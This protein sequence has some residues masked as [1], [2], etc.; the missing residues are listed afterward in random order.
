MAL[1]IL[2]I[3][4]SVRKDRIGIRPARYLHQLCASR[5]HEATLFDPLEY[6]LPL[7]DRMYKESPAGQHPA[8]PSGFV[9]RRI[10]GGGDLWV[11][12]YVITYDGRPFNTVSIME[13]QADKVVRETQYFAEPF[14]TPAW[15]AR[16]VEQMT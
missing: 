1:N 8:R 7:L 12:E 13:F 5:G 11:T 15:R 3:V 16:W 6:R 10:V 4:G 9:V 14:D 2:V